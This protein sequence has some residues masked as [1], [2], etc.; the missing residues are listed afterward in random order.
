M[1]RPLR[2]E[3]RGA[4]YHVTSRG[5]EK[6][7]IFRD[8]EDR[9]VFLDLLAKVNLRFNWLCHAYVLMNNHYH[10]VIETPE[11]NLSRG[12]RQL[13]GV[14]TQ[15]FN[16]RHKR[17]G[18]I[19]QGRYK[20][21][22]IQKESHLLEVCRYVVLNPVRAGAIKEPGKWK[23]S[24]YRATAGLVSLH[25][26]LTTDW[27]LGQFGIKTALARER[28]RQFVREGF[29]EEPIWEKVKGQI[30]FGEDDFAQRFIRHLR[31]HTDEK[32][33]PR[34]QRY[35]NRPILDALFKGNMIEDKRE[36]NR[37]IREAVEEYGY[38]QKEVADY[39]RMHYSTISRLMG[40]EEKSRVKT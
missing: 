27:I 32:E 40:K 16:R 7:P 35:I 39:L 26:C 10:I 28:Y 24:S 20:A 38:A 3:Y 18:H 22:L 33:I 29:K 11:G 9:R 21:I 13:N 37:R 5:N 2:I 30:L 34:S 15:A 19:F 25:P 4:V 17:T 6:R 1:A 14:Y 8:E 23:W 36:R 31:G 12:M